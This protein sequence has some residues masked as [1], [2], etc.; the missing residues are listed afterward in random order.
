MARAGDLSSERGPSGRALSRRLSLLY[1]RSPAL[2]P[3]HQSA[4]LEI[5]AG[6]DREPPRVARA[7]PVEGPA[8]KRVEFHGEPVVRFRAFLDGTQDS[9]VDRYVNGLPIVVGTA[10]AVVRERAGRRFVT[11][12][13]ARSSRVYA[14]LHEM[15]SAGDSTVAALEAGLGDALTDTSAAV[16]QATDG[17]PHPF[18]MQD[19]AVHAVQRERERLES[20]LGVAWCLERR[21][22]LFVD[23][24]IAG[25]PRLAGAANAVGVVKS[26]RAL[27][28]DGGILAVILTLAPGDR[29]T[30]FRIE[31][32]HARRS[33]V[34]SWYLRTRDA[35]GRDPLWGLVR[36]EVTP[37]G[38][39]AALASRADDV[40]RWILAEALPLA[41]PDPR[42]HNM[43][44]GIHDCEVFLRAI[45]A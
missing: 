11:W 33:S 26:H 6:S 2:D 39:A 30:V 4:T 41:L 13:Y 43:A 5:R 9:R 15:A 22:P 18:T 14:P 25:D 10:S 44:Y 38:S 45:H 1:P 16:A 37:D 23:G 28:G 29:S 40:S 12:R 7:L 35:A 34:A 32:G 8:I 31:P 27:Y 21:E 24:G 19:A 36:V 20:E 17:G 42:W 3:G